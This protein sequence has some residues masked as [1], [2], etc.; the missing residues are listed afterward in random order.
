[1]EY[2]ELVEKTVEMITELRNRTERDSS[3]VILNTLNNLVNIK[4]SDPKRQ[5]T[6]E[7]VARIVRDSFDDSIKEEAEAEKERIENNNA[8]PKF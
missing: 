4:D 5:E 2:E 8:I 6:K 3:L 7:I 1:M